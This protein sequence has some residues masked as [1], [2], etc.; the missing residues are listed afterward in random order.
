M[1]SKKNKSFADQAKKIM[2]K[3]ALRPDDNASKTAMN[4][5]LDILKEEQE[6]ERQQMAQEAMETLNSLGMAPPMQGAPQEMPPEMAM[7]Q[8]QGMPQQMPQQEMMGPPPQGM[9]MQQAY[10]GKMCGCGKR[11]CKGC[12]GK[13]KRAYGGNL[14][15]EGGILN[16]TEDTPGNPSVST[17]PRTKKPWEYYN[18]TNLENKINELDTAFTDPVTGER[19]TETQAKNT[20]MNLHSNV[21]RRFTEG[22]STNTSSIFH[23]RKDGERI[24]DEKGNYINLNNPE[25]DIAWSAATT[26]NLVMDLY[27]QDKKGIENIGFKPST[28]HSSYITDAFKSKNNPK[29]KYDL[30]QPLPIKSPTRGSNA[31]SLDQE[32]LNPILGI[33]DMLFFGRD[34]A[35]N[36]KFEDF[37]KAANKNSNYPSHS[38]I[39]TSKG[40]DEDGYYYVISGGNTSDEKSGLTKDTFGHKKV[41]YNP[42]SGE[43]IGQKSKK[44]FSNPYKGIMQIKETRR[45]M[46]NEPM[47]TLSPEQTKITPAEIRKSPEMM[48]QEMV[49][50]GFDPNQFA[51]GGNMRKKYAYGD[52]L[53]EDSALSKPIAY[54]EFTPDNLRINNLVLP[55]GRLKLDYLNSNNNFQEANNFTNQKDLDFL[56]TYS[57]IPESGYKSNP[58]D[59]K[60]DDSGNTFDGK[61]DTGDYIAAG[62]GALPDIAGLA[63]AA[64]KPEKRGRM[65]AQDE[66]LDTSAYDQALAR[67]AAQ[68]REISRRNP[69][70]ALS[71]QVAGTTAANTGIGAARA[72]AEQQMKARNIQRQ[73]GVDQFNLSQDERDRQAMDARMNAMVEH[74]KGITDAYTGVKGDKD[75]MAM[76]AQ[77]ANMLGTDNYEFQKNADGTVSIVPKGI[78]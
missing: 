63:Y 13:M 7:Q 72:S 64:K 12:G 20:I 67:N 32:E 58:N 46:S 31:A 11:G 42:N 16:T 40:S 28:A 9:P 57:K 73:M 1:A 62:I 52:Y 30:Y 23:E 38:D 51:Y 8:G 75:K 44:G 41:Y 66:T 45:A 2:S 6:I 33:G 27:N 35:K 36:W 49:S 34:R 71:Q 76:E 77:I 4:R 5:E 50:N 25:K 59:Q 19:L 56:N 70:A 37:E 55:H 10:G 69:N 29:H 68:T 48:Y 24:L 74:G 78:V 61:M 54:D 21:G 53:S 15:A 60:K 22:D 65:T 26:S 17:E 39:I 14:Y 18:P 3:Y 47:E 43:I